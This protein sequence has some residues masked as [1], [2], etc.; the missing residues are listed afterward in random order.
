MPFGNPELDHLFMDHFKP[1]VLQTGFTLKRLDEEQKAGLIDDQLRVEIRQSKFLLAELT[2]SNSGA[3]WE[4]GY[5]EGL[6]KP[7]IY[8]CSNEYF[9]KTVLILIQIIT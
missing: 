3:Y 2:E 9:Q 5:A 4:A 8:L 1:T 6:G 7:V